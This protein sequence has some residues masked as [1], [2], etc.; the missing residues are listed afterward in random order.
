MTMAAMRPFTQKTMMLLL[1]CFV[2]WEL[3]IVVKISP[4]LTRQRQSEPTTIGTKTRSNEPSKSRTK[5]ITKTKSYPSSR[6][7]IFPRRN[8]YQKSN[9]D[10]DK[11]TDNIFQRLLHHKR[12]NEGKVIYYLHIHKSAGSTMCLQAQKQLLQVNTGQNCNV[13]DDLHCCG[14]EDSLEAQISYANTTKYDFVASEREMYEAM[15][16]DYYDYVVTLRDSATRYLSHWN[17]LRTGAN[18]NPLYSNGNVTHSDETSRDSNS[19]I[20]IILNETTGLSKSSPYSQQPRPK[21]Q[22][23]DIHDK[24]IIKMETGRRYFV[25]N[26]S[27]WWDHQPDNYNT[28]MICGAKCLDSP[29]FQITSDLFEYT[30]QRLSLFSHVLFLED[31]EASY[32]RFARAVGWKR[33][34]NIK[35]QN[36]KMGASTKTLPEAM[37]KNNLKYDT[38]MTVLDD[39]LYAFAQKRHEGNYTNRN[40]TTYLVEEFVNSEG[41]QN[42]FR[43]GRKRNCKDPCCG[44]CSIW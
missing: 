3:F 35:H 21:I 33:N 16:T 32:V 2:S 18:L 38:L 36:K 40:K 5:I 24:Y 29:K 44:E 31:L 27:I 41:V 23:N 10:S 39:A 9:E 8:I 1:M 30:L 28:R 22:M 43:D 7:D 37:A 4:E 19:D 11:G 12:K 25:G 14:N 6:G 20:S 26:F 42:Y 34:S 17:H 13:Q 15:A